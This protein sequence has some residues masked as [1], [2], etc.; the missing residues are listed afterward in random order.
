MSKLRLL[1]YAMWAAVVLVA[2][3]VALITLLER[4]SERPTRTGI[5]D[6]GGPFR[7]LAHTGA[8]VDS[9]SLKG[10]PFAVFFGFTHCP[11]VCPTALSDL[12]ESLKV[13]GSDADRLQVLF[14]TVDPE[15]DTREVL[16]EYM[17]AFDPRILALTGTPAEIEAVL[18]AYKV[19]TAKVPGESGGY[20]MNHTASV[21]LMNRE[22]LFKSAISPAEPRETAVQKLRLLLRR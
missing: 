13:L 17:Q 7:L 6:I 20:T 18:K 12:S 19:F 16:A 9:E 2:S 11:D 15:R 21:Y 1:R 5:P 10:K 4:P 22:G 14:I 8:V 3:S